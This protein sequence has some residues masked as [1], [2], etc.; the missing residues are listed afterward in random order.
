MKHLI[1]S[2][3]TFLLV[4]LS[5]RANNLLLSTP[6]VNGSGQL[7][8]TIQ[9]DNSW[10]TSGLPFNWDA[11]WVFVKRQSCSNLVWSHVTLS[12]TSANHAVTGGVLQVDAVADGMGV[13]IRRSASGSGNIAASTVTLT[14]Q[15][16]LNTADN[17]LVYGIEM[18]AVPQGDF[19]LGDGLTTSNRFNSFTVTQ[20]MQNNG[21][22]AQSNYVCCSNGSTG[23]LPAAFPIG[24]NNF[25]CM[26][27]E[28]SQEQ[29]VG[30]LNTLTLA[31][32][33]NRTAVSPVSPVNTLAMFSSTANRNGIKIMSNAGP[34][35]YG[36]DLNNNNVYN[37]AADGQNIPCGMSV[38][39]AMAY[40]DWAALRPMTEFEFEK[41]CR[42]QATSAIAGE[43]AWGNTTAFQAHTG[44]LSN[45][46]TA[47]EIFTGTGS[48]GAG[49][50]VY[51]NSG[52]GPLRSGFAAQA[53][54]TRSQ[55]GASW[56]GIM[57][58]TGNMWEICVGGAQADY[59]SFTTTNGNG[60]LTAAG[61]SDLTGWPQ[62]YGSGTGCIIKGASYSEISTYCAVSDRYSATAGS[63]QSG[64]SAAIGPR[65]VRS[66]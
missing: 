52:G 39:D 47:S 35:V 60:A 56:Y 55:A 21:L 43:Y 58:L 36:C 33:Y 42:G 10:N 9:W 7:Q 53:A 29:Y 61:A 41:A 5:A 50:M 45:A 14:A 38:A 63:S 62:A 37:E 8:F 25:Y 66:F 13:F 6:S 59:S 16:A 40:L 12:T 34:A 19:I 65:G 30:F 22:G 28:L 24:W 4:S 3:L 11:V 27:Y 17:Y 15:T 32:Q 57:E 23:A 49:P 48:G 46:G 64:R 54:T 26:K 1:L 18:V 51:S 2:F 44:S 20:T 31:Q